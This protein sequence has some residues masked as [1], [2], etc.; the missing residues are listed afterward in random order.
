MILG[1]LQIYLLGVAVIGA[2]L[3]G[4]YS[5]GGW[6]AL[7]RAEAKRDRRLLS[8][9]KTAQEVSDNVKA[10]TDDALVRRANRWLLRD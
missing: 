4:I 8:V 1:R 3:M 10:E 6:A 2:A 5:A 9:Y 7:Q